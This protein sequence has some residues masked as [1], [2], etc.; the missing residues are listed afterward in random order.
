MSYRDTVLY[1]AYQEAAPPVHWA[2]H[3]ARILDYFRVS[4]GRTYTKA[5]ALKVSWCSYFVHWCLVKG[6]MSPLP[7]VG[8]AGEL[9]GMGSVG[10]FMK[11]SGGCYEAH[12]VY[13][14]QYH[15]RPGD[16]YNRIRPNNHIGFIRDVREISKGQYEILTIDGNSGPDWF[17]PYFDS[18]NL[19][20]KGFVYQ[21][22]EW[23]RLGGENWYIELCE[24][25]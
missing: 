5:N 14:R 18:S 17:S 24:D 16:M 21:R 20:G 19:I 11:P 25:D 12:G 10:R 4:T 13:R 23:I 15:P 9:G 2:Q 6:G 8:T 1:A 22:P 7:S 3:E